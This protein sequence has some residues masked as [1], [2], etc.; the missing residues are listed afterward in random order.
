MLDF[1]NVQPFVDLELPDWGLSHNLS[2]TEHE[3][4][5]D[6]RS[7]A[8]L[9]MQSLGERMVDRRIS[10][11]IE[12]RTNGEKTAYDMTIQTNFLVRTIIQPHSILP[13]SLIPAKLAPHSPQTF[14]YN[15]IR[16]LNGGG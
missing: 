3:K 13:V 14:F 8:F 9:M 6:T 1:T 7:W 12:F 2:S 11:H 5:T 15:S 16:H 10:H 4:P